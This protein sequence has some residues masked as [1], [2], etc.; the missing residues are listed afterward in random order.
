MKEHSGKRP[1]GLGKQ[2][3][4]L[5]ARIRGEHH[6]GVRKAFLSIFHGLGG[7]IVPWRRRRARRRGG[8]GEEGKEE[9][10]WV[11]EGKEEGG[12]GEEGK[13]EGGWGEEGKEE[14]EEGTEEEGGWGEEGKE[15]GGD[16]GEEEEGKVA[17]CRTGQHGNSL[18]HKCDVIWSTD[19]HSCTVS[20]SAS[21]P[22]SQYTHPN[23]G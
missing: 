20:Q 21:Q 7:W 4:S 9:G 16:L 18:G 6:R 23:Q 12:W 2:S 22:V 8:W 3:G 15:E 13:G 1:C 14:E 10:G 11:E 19:A 5:R 17:G